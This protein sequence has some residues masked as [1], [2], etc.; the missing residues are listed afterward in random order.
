[1]LKWEYKQTPEKYLISI[2]ER[3]IH[4]TP[5][6]RQKIMFKKLHVK[7]R[8]NKPAKL[9]V[10]RSKTSPLKEKLRKIQRTRPGTGVRLHEI[11]VKHAT[12][13]TVY[14]VSPFGK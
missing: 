12:A 11:V 14:T 4:L 8:Q 10:Q 5:G 13:Y 1:M 6:S 3:S 9:H 2:W 7:T